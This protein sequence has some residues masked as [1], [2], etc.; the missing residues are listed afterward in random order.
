[1]N[2]GGL[3]KYSG[4]N[5]NLLTFGCFVACAECSFDFLHKSTYL[6][7]K[8]MKFFINYNMLC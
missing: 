1:M 2:V 7:I 8:S 3:N 4:T 6:K 5:N